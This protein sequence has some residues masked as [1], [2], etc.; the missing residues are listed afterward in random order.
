MELLP[1]DFIWLNIIDL[2]TGQRKNKIALCAHPS[3]LLFFLVNTL[4]YNWASDGMFELSPTNL[5]ILKYNS[6]LNLSDL[7]TATADDY[8]LSNITNKFRLANEDQYK[9]ILYKLRQCTTLQRKRKKEICA[10]WEEYFGV[11]S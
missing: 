6:W 11:S 4:H 9:I 2:N 3:E 7:H 10:L 1:G 5:S 8:S